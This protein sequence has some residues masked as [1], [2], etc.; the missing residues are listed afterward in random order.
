L[1]HG[2]TRALDALIDH[3][4]PI[5]R[6]LLQCLKLRIDRLPLLLD[7]RLDL[8]AAVHAL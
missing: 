4:P 7:G 6:R 3:D 1:E 8:R 2:F 5:I